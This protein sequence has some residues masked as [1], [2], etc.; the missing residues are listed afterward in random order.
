MAEQVTGLLSPWLREKRINISRPY[1]KGRVLDYGC[2]VGML[3]EFCLPNAYLGVD[4]D[5]E[6]IQTAKTRYP[7]FR[8][9]LDV[10]EAEKFDTI[11]SL[12]V[13]EHVSN[14]ASL[15]KKFRVMLKPDGFI[16]LTTPHPT[17]EWLHTIGAKVGLF[18]SEANEEHEELIDSTI[19][20]EFSA[21]VGLRIVEY[22]KIL[23]GANQLFVLR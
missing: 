8:F 2:G 17:F 16:V 7:N 21:L 22:K 19:M 10:S 4:F 13:I 23:F 11:I 12:A 3:A 6:S 14:P 20:Q 18:S 9:D 1:I 15:L 5:K